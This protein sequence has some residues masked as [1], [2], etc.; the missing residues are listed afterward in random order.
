VAALELAVR[1]VRRPGPVELTWNWRW[2]LGILAS[3][4]AAAGLL[5]ST[6][7]LLGL[8]VA[9]G[10]GLTAGAAALLFLPSARHWAIDMFWCLVTPHRVRA[11]CVNAWL[12]TRDGRLPFVTSAVP[13]EYGQQV[14]LWLRAGLTAGDLH[15]ARDVLAAACWATEVRVVPSARYAQLVTLQVIRKRRARPAWP[16]PR[17]G[18]GDGHGVSGERDTRYPS[19]GFPLAS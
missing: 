8:S 19:G 12:Q 7:G 3:L 9:T 17:T 15:A 1:G 6:A 2:E 10:A 16:S 18:A 11:G 5:V 4:S 14:R 13:A